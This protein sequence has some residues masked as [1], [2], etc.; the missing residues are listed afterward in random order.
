MCLIV[1]TAEQCTNCRTINVECRNFN[2]TIGSCI[3][4][5]FELDHSL[6]YKHR[7]PQCG[8]LSVWSGSELS[9]HRT[10]QTSA[11]C[12]MGRRTEVRHR[13]WIVWEKSALW[14]WR[15]RHI[16]RAQHCRQ[17]YQAQRSWWYQVRFGLKAQ[18]DQKH[19]TSNA[20]ALSS[21]T[22]ILITTCKW[23]V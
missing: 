9:P 13:C 6:R 15:H 3:K 7:G 14:E 20:M 17:D 23:P 1:Q 22:I 21:P 18:H 2:R 10:Q 4:S 16:G 8:T 19:D 11:W 5:L 12:H